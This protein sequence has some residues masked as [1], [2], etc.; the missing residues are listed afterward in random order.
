MLTLTMLVCIVWL[1]LKGI[2]IW[3]INT[4]VVWGFAIA[5][6]VWW[7]GI[8]NAG[9]LISSMLL[10]DAAEVARLDQPLRRGDDAV[11]R[12]PSPG[13]FRSCISAGRSISTGSRPIPTR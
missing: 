10:L 3:G 2:G 6:Y 8:G 4:V 13:C 9:T 12:R 5:N 11:R 7:I 1:F